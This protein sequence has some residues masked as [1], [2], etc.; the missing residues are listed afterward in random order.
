MTLGGVSF[1]EAEAI[2]P[3]NLCRHGGIS[4]TPCCFNEAEAIKPRN[5]GLHELAEWLMTELQ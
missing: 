1:N 3:R 4:P 5:Q 2:K